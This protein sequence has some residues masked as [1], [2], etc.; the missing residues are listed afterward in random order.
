MSSLF[1][2]YKEVR[3]QYWMWCH[4]S[5]Q[6]VWGGVKSSDGMF[7]GKW[8]TEFCVCFGM[9][10]SR[11]VQHRHISQNSCITTNYVL[12]QTRRSDH[13]EKKTWHHEW[14]RAKH[15]EGQI[16]S[17]VSLIFLIIADIFNQGH[18]RHLL[19]VEV[20]RQT[21]RLYERMLSC[22]S[23]SVC[24]NGITLVFMYSTKNWSI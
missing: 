19:N 10:Q 9:Q 23:F 1:R 15:C 22:L 24:L 14:F 8:N 11:T 5:A 13:L 16:G 17:V 18:W 7:T 6:C 20:H 3:A 4:Q 21:I 2:Y 12:C